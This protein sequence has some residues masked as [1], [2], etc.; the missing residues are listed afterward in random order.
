MQDTKEKIL[1]AALKLFAQDGYKAV[2]VSQI[3]GALGM[4]KGALYK[5]YKNKRDIFAHIVAH[6]EAQDAQEASEHQVPG[7]H[8]G[9]GHRSLCRHP[10]FSHS[11]LQPIHV[12]LLDSRPLRS[13]IPEAADPGAVSGR[14][15]GAAVSAIFVRRAAGLSERS[16]RQPGIRPTSGAALT[17]YAPM[18]F[19]YSVYDGQGDTPLLQQL[20]NAHWAKMWAQ[21]GRGRLTLKT[22]IEIIQIEVICDE[23]LHCRVRNRLTNQPHRLEVFL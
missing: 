2:S 1:L 12:P 21:M 3:A 18:F 10:L 8:A 15:D 23:A 6:M 20:L 5:H 13:P 11:D 17:F 7:R 19:L 9:G 16:V 22:D 4:T 14:G